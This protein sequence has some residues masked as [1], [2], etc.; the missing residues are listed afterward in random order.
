MPQQRVYAAYA[1][2]LKEDSWQIVVP[3]TTR[4]SP[5][6]LNTD[7]Q[8]KAEAEAWMLSDRGR[9]LLAAAQRGRPP[10]YTPPEDPTGAFQLDAELGS[11]L[12]TPN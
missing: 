9:S 7:F 1:A 3:T 11:M 10:T 2:K 4:I 6:S 12:Q 8:S 5:I